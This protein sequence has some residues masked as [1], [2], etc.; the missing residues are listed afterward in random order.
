MGSTTSFRA[1][2]SVE[3]EAE[4]MN[5]TETKPPALASG[6]SGLTGE[7]ARAD[8]QKHFRSSLARRTLTLGP[9]GRP[10]VKYLVSRGQVSL[11]LYDCYNRRRQLK[12]LCLGINA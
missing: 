10:G 6:R 3:E 4:I 8:F 1:A 12:L 5:G 2:L 9:R 7:C 11:R